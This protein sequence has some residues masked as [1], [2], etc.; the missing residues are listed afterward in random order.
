MRYLLVA[1]ALYAIPGSAAS[2][3]NLWQEWYLVTQNGQGIS[4]FEETYEIRAKEKQVA[5][6]QKWIEKAAGARSE[7][8]IGSVAEEGSLAPVAFFSER[9]GPKAY[10]IDGRVADKKLEVTFKPGSPDLAKSTDFLP[11]SPGIAFSSLIP[12]A[13]ARQFNE[14]K[15]SLDFTAIVEDGGDMNVEVKKGSAEIGT[16]EKKIGKE[17]CRG[18]VLQFNGQTQEWW[19]TKKG[20]VCLVEFPSSGVRMELSTEKAAKK[21]LNEK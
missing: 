11:L 4:L 2:S 20:K 18:A 7:V 8:Y 6:T 16:V 15:K 19:I 1:L 3:K 14:N 17:T 9:K 10:K 5:V 13:I 12:T 21:A